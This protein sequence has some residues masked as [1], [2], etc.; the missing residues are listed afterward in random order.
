VNLTH[1]EIAGILTLRPGVVFQDGPYRL[2]IDDVT[3]PTGMV[4]INQIGFGAQGV[5]VRFPPEYTRQDQSFSLTQSWLDGA[6]L[7]IVRLTREGS[8]ERELSFDFTVLP[9]SSG[10]P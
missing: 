7:V 3:E 10:T 4:R 9:V 1:E 8:V 6:E 2:A 5:L